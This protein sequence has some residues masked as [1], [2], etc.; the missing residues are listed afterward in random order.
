MIFDFSLHKCE[1]GGKWPLCKYG[2]MWIIQNSRT[3]HAVC[4]LFFSV[5][6]FFFIVDV[7]LSQWFV[8][9]PVCMSIINQTRLKVIDQKPLHQIRNNLPKKKRKKQQKMYKTLK[10]RCSTSFREMLLPFIATVGRKRGWSKRSTARQ[11][12]TEWAD[13]AWQRFPISALPCVERKWLKTTILHENTWKELSPPPPS[14]FSLFCFSH[15][16]QQKWKWP[17]ISSISPLPFPWNLRCF[18]PWKYIT[19]KNTRQSEMIRCDFF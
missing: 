18:S 13:H 8:F 6:T 12:F 16:T 7:F 10:K 3:K 15:F 11:R 4:V 14:T 9:S 19:T 2:P 5:G 1:S 17:H